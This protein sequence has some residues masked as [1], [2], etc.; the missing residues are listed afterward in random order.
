M[1]NIVAIEAFISVASHSSFS[2]AAKE[3][4]MARTG[5]SKH[6]GDLELELGTRLFNRTTRNVELTEAG[7]T[8]Y[9]WSQLAVDILKEGHEAA[10]EFG[11]RPMGHLRIAAPI[12]FGTHYMAPVVAAFRKL[13]PD[14]TIDIILN[15]QTVDLVEGR[16]DVALRIGDLDGSN[17]RHQEITSIRRVICASPD[18]IANRKIQKK[19]E[20]IHEHE[21]ISYSHMAR[22]LVWSFLPVGRANSSSITIK[23][24]GPINSNNGDFLIKLAKEGQGIIN[25]PLFLVKNELAT[26]ELVQV[27]PKFEL[28]SLALYAVYPS[29]KHTPVKLR[30]FVDLMLKYFGDETDWQT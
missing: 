7:E 29:D 24:N 4:S 11:E 2:K 22:N 21:C 3:L 16:F 14:V 8:Y 27:L 5:V 23:A 10:S 9:H 19:P 17:M 20:D 28:P 25:V 18:F 26:G 12:S 6:I 1:P 30:H 15:D 13:N